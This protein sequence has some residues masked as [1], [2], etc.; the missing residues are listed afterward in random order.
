MPSLPILSSAV[1]FGGPRFIGN[2]Q[3]HLKSR[4]QQHFLDVKK[5]DSC[6]KDFSTQFTETTV[7]SKAKHDGISCSIIGQRNSISVVKTFGARNCALL[8]CVQEQLFSNNSNPINNFFSIPT[9]KS[10]V[11]VDIDPTSIACEADRPQHWRVNQW[12][13]SQ[14]D[15]WSC[16]KCQQVSRLPSWCPTGSTAR[17]NK[18]MLFSKQQP[19]KAIPLITINQSL[20]AV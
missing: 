13:K 4:M 14:P 6:A 3:Q 12:Q 19:R 15:T 5:T 18:K 17:A 9:M 10:A 16:H 11:L 7:S 20:F 1:S 8:H 2:T